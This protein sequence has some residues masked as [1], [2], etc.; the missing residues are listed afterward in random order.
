ME[1]TLKDTGG[2]LKN[3]GMAVLTGKNVAAAV[4]RALVIVIVRKQPGV[5]A[6]LDH[7]E[8]HLRLVV[9]LQRRACLT[10]RW[11]GS[12]GSDDLKNQGEVACLLPFGWR[13][14]HAVEPG[15]TGLH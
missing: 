7:D 12:E 9:R 3:N 8:R 4:D 11:V 5:V 14:A 2:N 13:R 10:D 1:N 6:L 15:R